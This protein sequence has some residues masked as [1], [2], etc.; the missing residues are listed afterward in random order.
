MSVTEKQLKKLYKLCVKVEAHS[1]LD[2][3]VTIGGNGCN[4]FEASYVTNE[5]CGMLQF[6][7]AQFQKD[8]EKLVQ[9]LDDF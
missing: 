5:I 9:E 4:A 7:Q 1:Q 3:E 6:D 8:V 2:F